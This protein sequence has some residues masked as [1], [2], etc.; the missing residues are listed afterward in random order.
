MGVTMC[1]NKGDRS[2]DLTYNGFLRFRSRVSM[3]ACPEW[4]E[5][6]SELSKA[7]GL[8][9]DEKNK[10]FDELEETTDAMVKSKKVS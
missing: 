1:C 2:I 3:L 9:E 8:P 5:K 4:G 7:Y 6:Y 10:F